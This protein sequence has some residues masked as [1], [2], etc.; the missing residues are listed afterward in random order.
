MNVI[1]IVCQDYPK[2]GEYLEF[3]K[4][5]Y[6]GLDVQITALF[7]KSEISRKHYS[8]FSIQVNKGDREVERR[9]FKEIDRVLG[10]RI[11]KKTRG[12]EKI[13]Q[14]LAEIERGDYQMLIWGD[15]D[16]GETKKIAE[17]SMIPTLI[18]RKGNKLENIL[19]CSDGSECALRAARFSCKLAEKQGAVPTI[20]SVART[21]NDKQLAEEAMDLTESILQDYDIKD[22]KSRIEIGEPKDVILSLEKDYDLVVLAPRGLGKVKRILL[23][24]VSLLVLEKAQSNILMVR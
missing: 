23:S 13:S 18:Y 22:L 4:R 16:R 21:P 11:K 9:L 2:F 5:I 7:V 19:I 24:H 14:V 10:K 3:I 1:F 17:Y 20:L 6:S 12:G 15:S 8:P